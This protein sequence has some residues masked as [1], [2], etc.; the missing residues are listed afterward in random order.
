MVG[1][2]MFQRGKSPESLQLP[3]PRWDSQATPCSWKCFR[4]RSAPKF[5]KSYWNSDQLLFHLFPITVHICISCI[6]NI[7]IW[8]CI[9]YIYVYTWL[10]TL[11][12]LVWMQRL[13]DVLLVSDEKTHPTI[14][15]H[16]NQL[17]KSPP[18]V[19]SWHE[20][21]QV[22]QGVDVL[23]AARGPGG[24]NMDYPWT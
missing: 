21:G 5:V 19:W 13:L 17:V 6:Y 8:I 12:F 23:A 20:A 10:H 14:L 1:F 3:R 11:D 22:P 7:C 24:V 18:M 4:G 9:I 2:P 16:N 15:G